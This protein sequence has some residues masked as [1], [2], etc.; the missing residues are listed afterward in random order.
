MYSRT[1]TVQQDRP[2]GWPVQAMQAYKQ[3][4]EGELRV[5]TGDKPLEEA[6]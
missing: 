4:N 5:A 6:D 2:E 1:E 3:G